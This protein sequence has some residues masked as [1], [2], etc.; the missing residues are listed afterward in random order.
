MTH[1]SKP[2]P[3]SYLY[4]KDILTDFTML[5]INREELIKHKTLFS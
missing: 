4:E 5:H 3:K 2:K 1:M